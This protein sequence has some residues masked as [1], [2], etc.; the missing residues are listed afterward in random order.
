MCGVVLETQV[1]SVHVVA[2]LLWPLFGHGGGPS[3]PGLVVLSTCQ[4]FVS[5]FKLSYLTARD[6]LYGTRLVQVEVHI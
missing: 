2:V 6:L 4:H 5:G 3:N 1:R